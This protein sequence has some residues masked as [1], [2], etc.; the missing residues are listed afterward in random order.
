MKTNHSFFR[1]LLILFLANLFPVNS[2]AFDVGGNITTDTTWT[3]ENSPYTVTSNIQ[4]YPD[5]KLTIEPGVTVQ[6]S[7]GTSITVGGELIAIGTA[8]DNIIF[9]SNEGSPTSGDWGPIQFIDGSIGSTISEEGEYISGSVFSHCKIEYGK[10]ILSAFSLFATHNTILNNNSSGLAVGGTSVVTNNTIKYNRQGITITGTYGNTTVNINVTDNIIE[11]NGGIYG[12]GGIGFGTAVTG[13]VNVLNNLIKNNSASNGG[14]ICLLGGPEGNPVNMTIK[15][16]I[17]DGNIASSDGGGIHSGYGST[18]L[19]EDNDISNN[20]A[21]SQGGGLR[22][23]GGTTV[24]YN[25]INSNTAGDAGG[26]VWIFGGSLNS[27]SIYGNNCNLGS[28]IYIY[29]GEVQGNNITNNTGTYT[30]AKTFSNDISIPGNYWGTVDTTIIDS[31]IYDFYDVIT[32][33]KILYTPISQQ[34]FDF[35]GGNISGTVSDQDS[36]LPISGATISCSTGTALT[37]DVGYYTIN[38]LSPG[39]YDIT[40]TATNYDSTI[41]KDVSVNFGTTQSINITLTLSNIP[42]AAD[43]GP[44][45]IVFNTVTLDGSS[46]SD[47]DGNIVSWEWSL[48]H[49]TNPANNRSA[50]GEIVSIDSLPSGFY[51]VVLVV[52]DQDGDSSSDTAVI[53]ATGTTPG[54]INYDGKIGLEEAINALK[55]SSGINPQ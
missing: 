8:S 27:N 20:S 33:G 1:T 13:T 38:N 14:G 53:A 34:P 12:G 40:A 5:I 48:T 26:G 29:D 16:N 28:A 24:R 52:T 41:I 17:I 35:S 15:G 55:V 39:S 4:I 54:D 46:S 51:D 10:G 31:L 22:I 42:P 25:R 6:F 19:V 32:L 9:T 7:K 23:S 50:N 18:I 49:K 21:T 30:I 37:N 43:A 11:Q 36:G 44:D 3:V 47:Q 2:F 45:K